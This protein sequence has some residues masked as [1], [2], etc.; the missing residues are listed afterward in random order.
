MA[1]K[2]ASDKKEKE[3]VFIVRAATKHGGL[4][5]FHITLIA[6]VIVLVAL[7]FSLSLF[8]PGPTVKDCPY[9]VLANYSCAPL[10]YTNAQVT[11]AV[12]RIIAGY[13][14]INGSL[15][16]LPFYT[17]I[18]ESNVSYL[19]SQKEWFVRVPYIDPLDK[20]AVLNASFLLSQNLTLVDSFISTASSAIATN[21][22]VVALGTV[23]VSGRYL[24][25]YSKP[26]P[27]YFITD[28]YAPGA[29]GAMA[30]AINI[31]RENE[32]SINMS[33]YFFFSQYS[34]S[35]YGRYGE[36]N[37]QQLGDY[38]SCAAAQGRLPEFLSNLSTVYDGVPLQNLTLEGIATES[39]LDQAALQGCFLNVTKVL[40]NQAALI[41]FYNVTSV[42]I[43]IVDCKYQSL[44]QTV[45][46]AINYTMNEI[47]TR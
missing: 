15:S 42:P 17:L 30:K 47:T 31:S 39:D 14:F 9:G 24:C 10:E 27:T 19:P 38:L 21:N 34:E 22:S 29:L 28:P 2:K 7:A 41:S 20:N 5:Y 37:T 12:G 18:N 11:Q 44:P 46:Y 32:G 43:F 35:F 33:Y 13:S 3:P 26:V 6:L 16:L 23:S 8:R 45:N 1:T 25:S 40:D 4:D 36:A